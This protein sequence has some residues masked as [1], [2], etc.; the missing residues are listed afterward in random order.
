L[1]TALVALAFFGVHDAAAHGSGHHALERAT[2]S[3]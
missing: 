2:D 3:E 1:P